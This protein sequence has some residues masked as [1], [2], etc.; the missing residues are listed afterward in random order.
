MDDSYDMLKE[1][2][3]ANQ[4]G[5]KRHKPSIFKT[6]ISCFGPFYAYIGFL[7]IITDLINFIQPQLLK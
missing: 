3:S 4:D 6:L 7:K 5:E 2:H 1:I